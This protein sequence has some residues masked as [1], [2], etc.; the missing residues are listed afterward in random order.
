MQR[1]LGQSCLEDLA[2]TPN[3]RAGAPSPAWPEVACIRLPHPFYRFP[4]TQQLMRNCTDLDGRWER[5]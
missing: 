4:V 1:I 3:C 2:G 5:Q